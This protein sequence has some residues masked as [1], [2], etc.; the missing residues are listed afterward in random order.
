MAESESV[1]AVVLN[2]DDDANQQI[3]RPNAVTNTTDTRVMTPETDVPTSAPTSAPASRRDPVTHTKEVESLR[4]IMDRLDEPEQ[5]VNNVDHFSSVDNGASRTETV[6]NA[7]T[8]DTQGVTGLKDSITSEFNEVLSGMRVDMITIVKLLQTLHGKT[9]T[10]GGDADQIRGDIYNL[11]QA[12]DKMKSKIEIVND[13]SIRRQQK[14]TSKLE[15]QIEKMVQRIEALERANFTTNE[16][17]MR[18]NRT[19][20]QTARTVQ[21]VQTVQT[22]PSTPSIPPTQ[23]GTD[24][25]ATQVQDIQDAQSSSRVQG[26]RVRPKRTGTKDRVGDQAEAASTYSRSSRSAS[27]AGQYED[28]VH[29]ESVKSSKMANRGLR[30]NVNPRKPQKPRKDVIQN[31]GSLNLVAN[32]NNRDSGSEEVVDDDYNDDTAVTDEVESEDA[33]PLQKIITRFI[34]DAKK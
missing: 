14:A 7:E 28:R 9:D 12:I 15:G 23:T 2:T 5:A 17:V 29:S 31:G 26:I 21:T 19:S 24:T 25:R 10:L 34:P 4:S 20:T 27:R 3:F 16:P 22:T 6:R 8:Y 13:N 1:Q 11:V 18:E 32:A 30:D 33:E